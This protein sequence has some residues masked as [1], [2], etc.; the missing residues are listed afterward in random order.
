MSRLRCCARP[1]GQHSRWPSENAL[2]LAQLAHCRLLPAVLPPCS[3]SAAV[4]PLAMTDRCGAGPVA[5]LPLADSG[6]QLGRCSVRAAAN[7]LAGS[8]RQRGSTPTGQPK[9]LWHWPNDS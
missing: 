9:L 7:W 3:A 5:S 2:E 6:A 8:L 4:L 1:A